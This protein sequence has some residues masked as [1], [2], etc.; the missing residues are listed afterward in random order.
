MVTK[1]SKSTK[2][3]ASKGRTSGRT[4]TS[5]SSIAAARKDLRVLERRESA[6][7]AALKAQ[8][9][10]LKRLRA[11]AEDH[12]ASLKSLKS[13]LKDAAKTRKTLQHTQT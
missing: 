2:T 10:A 8:T 11:A 4:Q 13:E 3:A 7:R 1:V 6:L 12:R 5:P 9:R